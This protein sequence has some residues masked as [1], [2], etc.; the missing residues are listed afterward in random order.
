MNSQQI[1]N[2]PGEISLL[3]D[4]EL[5]R[6]AGTYTTVDSAPRQLAVLRKPYFTPLFL[7]VFLIFSVLTAQYVDF[8]HL[9]YG[10]VLGSLTRVSNQSVLFQGTLGF[11]PF[12][13]LFVVILGLFAAGS[14]S[15]RLRM[16]IS[17]ALMYIA[18][19]LV[20][21]L[22]VLRVGTPIGGAPFSLLGSVL[23][24]FAGMFLIVFNTLIWYRLPDRITVE[25]RVR[26]SHLYSLVAIIS[27]MVSA[28]I[29]V[30]ILQ[31][32]EKHI[33][34]LKDVALLG[35]LGPGIIL[36]FPV[37]SVLLCLTGLIQMR[38]RRTQVQSES[39][40]RG[41]PS[42]AFLVPAYNEEERIAACIISLQRA[43]FRYAG[44]ARL[45]IVN[46][47]SKDNTAFVAE[48][49]IYSAERGM[50]DGNLFFC[51]EPGKAKA[52]NFGLS[53]IRE[54]IIV[55]VDADTTVEP[56]LLN[57]I[58]P[59]FLDPTVGAVGGKPVPRYPNSLISRIRNIEIV[60]NF[61]VKRMAQSAV[62]SIVVLT[63]RI[64]AYRRELLEE[65]GGFG[66]GFN[67][68]DTDVAVQI[69]RLGYKVVL[70]T[71][72]HVYSDEP[73]SLGE[74]REQR[75]RWSRS[76][77]HVVAR[78]LSALWMRQGIRGIWMIP[79]AMFGICRRA[80][81]VPIMLYA[82]TILAI[83]PDDL[84]LRHGAAIAAVFLGP[85]LFI[86]TGALI[87]RRQFNL[88]PL[89]PAYMLFRLFRAYIA[90]E[91]MQ[92]LLLQPLHAESSNREVIQS[93]ALESKQ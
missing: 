42:V 80:I 91:S 65:L 57:K 55:R 71:S 64:S 44:Y 47:A 50:V 5:P 60:D 30:V 11:R 36:F 62:D 82:T 53:K 49:E 15:Q 48:Q 18:I 28:S 21:D 9:A 89:V 12:F 7:F 88:L 81:V 25:T 33:N 59:Y 45:Y 78:N 73:G 3:L 34:F 63:G 39:T 66:E 32:G 61:D 87:A 69:G 4:G 38:V 19:I 51:G 40:S 31:Y 90:L 35:G 52:L 92:G 72:I 26:R 67:G 83:S 29:V 8:I 41:W 74:L 20:I 77:F 76:S 2:E 58:V 22:S 84:F 27:V 75:I 70:D 10:K 86:V 14:I 85:Q 54:E 56:L 6:G 93:F 46:N 68:E 79:L 23:T 43:A 37:L 16:S 24:G 1:R 17:S 13:L